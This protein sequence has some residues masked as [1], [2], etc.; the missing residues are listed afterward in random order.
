MDVVMRKRAAIALTVIPTAR[1]TNRSLA[2][3]KKTTV[4]ATSKA[5]ECAFRRGLRLRQFS[6]YTERLLVMT[7]TFYCTADWSCYSVVI[8]TVVRLQRVIVWACSN[9]AIV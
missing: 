8:W 6:F 5:D 2:E 3:Q 1:N 4:Q 7:F 9:H